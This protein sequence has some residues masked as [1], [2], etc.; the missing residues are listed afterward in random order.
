MG[1]HPKGI[2]FDP[3]KLKH[4]MDR[5]G[6]SSAQQVVNWFLDAYWWKNQPN[7][8]REEGIPLPADYVEMKGVGIAGKPGVS[9]T[10]N[11]TIKPAFSIPPPVIDQYGAYK[12]ELERADSVQEI[13]GIN[14]VLQKDSLLT[15]G[16]K[17]S[18]E[19]FGKEVSKNLNV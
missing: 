2:R 12:E 16:Q 13:E 18:L 6:L 15:P 19:L 17:R 3:V 4:V 8:F 9:V 1:N 7:P 14:K 10:G 5:E 11:G